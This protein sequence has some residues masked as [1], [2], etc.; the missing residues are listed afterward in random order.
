MTLTE[1]IAYIKGLTEGLKLDADKDEVKVINA[2]IDVLDDMAKGITTLADTVDDAVYQLDEVDENLSMLEDV[3]YG[4][5][6]FDDCGCDDCCDCD[7]DE[8]VFYEVT[9]PTCGE[10]INV[11]EDILL[12]GETECPKCGE[13]LEFDFSTLFEDGEEGVC[14]CGCD[15]CT[16]H[17]SDCDCSSEQE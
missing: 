10:Q 14:G 6:D 12:C 2:I 9:C 11:E 1:K 16:D 17:H 15:D 3:V 5:E 7:E 13:V 4:E 8:N